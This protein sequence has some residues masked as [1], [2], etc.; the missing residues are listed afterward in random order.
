MTSIIDRV[1][2]AYTSRFVLR[3]EMDAQVRAEVAPFIASLL[4]GQDMVRIT[5]RYPNCAGR[6]DRR[7]T[8]TLCLADTTASHVS[9]A[10]CPRGA[11]LSTVSKYMSEIGR[12]LKNDE[13]AGHF[14]S[15]YR[16]NRSQ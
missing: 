7:Q 3:P 8:K 4:S 10:D 13:P 16:F 6:I 1:T 5:Y 14:N 11:V 2:A 9:A 15:S 12:T